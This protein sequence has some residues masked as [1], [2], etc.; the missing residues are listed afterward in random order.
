MLGKLLL[1]EDRDFHTIQAVEGAFKQVARWR[2]TDAGAHALIA[3]VRYLAA[4]SP[5]VRAQEQTF[6]IAQRLHRGERLFEE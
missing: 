5:T 4:H 2:G 1:R 3:A 6:S